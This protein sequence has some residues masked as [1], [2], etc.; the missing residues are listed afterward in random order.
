MIGGMF[1]LFALLRDPDEEIDNDRLMRDIREQFA[2]AREYEVFE[3]ELVFPKFT[4]VVMRKDAWKASFQIR[5]D[6][7]RS[8]NLGPLRRAIG[9]RKLPP[10]FLEYDTEIA[11]RFDDDPEREYTDE[12]IN[13]GEFMRETYPGIVLLTSAGGLW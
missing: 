10:D 4:D 2:W 11:I 3:H 1:T 7:G 6:T 12:I 9:V 8:I 13:I 5:R